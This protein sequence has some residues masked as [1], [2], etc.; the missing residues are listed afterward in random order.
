[1]QCHLV[2]PSL[3]EK[4][5]SELAKK[6]LERTLKNYERFKDNPLEEIIKISQSYDEGYIERDLK[7]DFEY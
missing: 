4:H 5:A 3:K 7:Y 1:M 2:F 6:A